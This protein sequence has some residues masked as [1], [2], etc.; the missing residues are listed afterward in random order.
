MSR[1]RT[2]KRKG[3]TPTTWWQALLMG[4]TS[5]EVGSTGPLRF[6]PDVTGNPGDDWGPDGQQPTGCAV[7]CPPGCTGQGD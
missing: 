5:W 6:R 2:R 4:R 3:P 1:T 7:H